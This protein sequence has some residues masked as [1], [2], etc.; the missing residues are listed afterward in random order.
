MNSLPEKILNYFGGTDSDWYNYKWQYKNI[1]RDEKPLFDLIE[2]GEE[3][4]K[5]VKKAVKNNIPFG[6]TPYYLS[7]ID[8]NLSVGYDHAIRKQVIPTSDYVNIMSEN[9][10]KRNEVLILWENMTLLQ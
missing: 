5:A 9:S 1:I 10:E 3:Q 2:L 8:Y 7:L 4:K 6:I